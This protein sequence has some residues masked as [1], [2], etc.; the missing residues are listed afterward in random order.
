MA[1]SDLCLGSPV[2]V[3]WKAGNGRSI[4]IGVD[5]IVGINSEFILP[6]DLRIYLFE[7][8]ITTLYD[9]QFFDSGQQHW[10]LATDLDLDGSLKEI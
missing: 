5:P 1:L 10:L 8:G 3:G 6:E 9:A 2:I 4:C 7:Y